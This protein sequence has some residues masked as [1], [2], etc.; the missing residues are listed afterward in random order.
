MYYLFSLNLKGTDLND[1]IGRKTFISLKDKVERR[2]KEKADCPG[3][4]YD[5]VTKDKFYANSIFAANQIPCIPNAAIIIDNRIIFPGNLVKGI[6]AIRSLK[7]TFFIKNTVLEAGDGVL[8]CIITEDQIIMNDELVSFESFKNKLKNKVWV[9]QHQFFSHQDIRKVNPTALNTT[10]IVTILNGKE[11]EYLAG[12]QGFA[13]NNATMD[14]WSKNSIYVGIDVKKSCLKEFGYCNLNVKDKS[15]VT[16]HPDSKVT[17]KD[18]KLPY[19]KEAVELCIKAHNLLF[20]NFVIGWDVA[21]TET[22]PIIVEANEKPGMN[23]TQSI[24]GGLKMKIIQN[25]QKYLIG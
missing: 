7:G 22:G 19:L 2:L 20:F 18:Y 10:R 14:S 21:I 1:Y 24:D 12:F 23:V 3:M 9:V 11:P 6:D 8:T 17:F 5:V 15:L 25:A 16:E 4:N 13:T